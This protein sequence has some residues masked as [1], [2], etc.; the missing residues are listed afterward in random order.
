MA[1]QPIGIAVG[2]EHRQKV[3][4]QLAGGVFDREIFLMVA[5]H[6]DQHFFRQREILLIEAAEDG[7]GPLRQVDDG[8]QQLRVFAP[9]R[10]GTVRVA[11]SRALRILYSRSALDCQ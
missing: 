4:R 3:R 5:H 8:L 6:R 7:R 1:D 10:A 11:A 9:A 2:V